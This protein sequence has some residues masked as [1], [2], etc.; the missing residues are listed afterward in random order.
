MIEKE[1]SE[2][3]LAKK[4]SSIKHARAAVP[5]PKGKAADSHKIS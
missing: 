4:E 3:F 1:D 2:I 5:Q